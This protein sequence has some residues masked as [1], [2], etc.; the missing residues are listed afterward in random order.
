MGIEP[1]SLECGSV[2]TIIK[3]EYM[4]K[5]CFLMIAFLVVFSSTAFA[6]STI[7]IDAYSDLKEYIGIPE[8]NITDA[9]I[10]SILIM[11]QFWVM[12]QQEIWNMTYLL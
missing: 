12:T 8:E 3:E 10:I 6:N 1:Y 7:S 5:I 2:H 4:K 11:L 9:G